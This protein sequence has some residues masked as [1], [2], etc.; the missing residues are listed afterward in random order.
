ME[1][2]QQVTV[3]DFAS[4]FGTT[5]EAMP[6]ICKR[7]IAEKDFGYRVL[8]AEERDRVILDVLKKIESDTQIIGEPRRRDTWEKGWDENLQDFTKSD[9]DLDTLVPRFIRPDNM[10]RLFG[11]Y[12]EP[13]N[14]SFELDY[15]SV[16]RLWLFNEYLSDV[17]T[18][19]EFGCGTGFNLVS[20]AQ[21]YPDKTLHGLD[22]VSPP[23]DLVNK[24]AEA[25]GYNMT[26]HIFDMRDPDQTLE[27][28][29]NSAVYT[30]GTI[31]QLASDFEPFLQF[32]LER[33]PALCFNVE[34]TLE[35]YKQDNLVDHLAA[36]FHKKRGYTQ[37]YLPRL[38]ELHDEGKIELMK[39]KRLF[40]GSLFMEGYTLMVWRPL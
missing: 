19:Y 30:I 31:E 28:A 20:L 37:G 21:S 4:S 1:C 14:P 32:L 38:Q 10:I 34:P 6:E 9:C 2:L 13:T 7:L 18:V 15:F 24:I 39:V 36:S 22:F 17:K 27:I 26:G 29:D 33:R 5:A 8:T 25:Y 11:D 3:E 16:F 40:F 23:R 35:L 12:V